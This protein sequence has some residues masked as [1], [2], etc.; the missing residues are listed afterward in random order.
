MMKSF[1]A[2]FALGL[3]VSSVVG[4]T[5]VSAEPLPTWYG[6]YVW[7]ESLGRIGGSTPSEGVVAFVTYTLAL[8]PNAGATG[9]RVSIEGFQ[10]YETMKCT[11]TPQMNQLII[12]FYRFDADN[13]ARGGRY[14]LGTELFTM[15]RTVNGLT[16]RLQAM[17]ASS[18]ASPRT[19]RLFLKV[20]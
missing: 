11:A 16:T 14:A 5:G 10:R 18:D 3:V 13:T 9:C 12:K 6:R 20:R 4:T 2:A 8:G 7:E 19:G 15:T 17:G 1:K